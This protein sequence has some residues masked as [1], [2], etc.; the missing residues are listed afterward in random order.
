MINGVMSTIPP[1]AAP[2]TEL[3]TRA[4]FAV[5]SA[6]ATLP[7]PWPSAVHILDH[8]AGNVNIKLCYNDHFFD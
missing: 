2:S 6:S 7:K 4:A 1:P 5:R 8:C 3:T